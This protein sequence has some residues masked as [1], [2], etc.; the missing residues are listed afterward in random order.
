MAG[1][2]V[3]QAPVT[4][5]PSADVIDEMLEGYPEAEQEIPEPRIDIH[6]PIVPSNILDNAM[7][8]T[9]VNL[10]YPNEVV[11]LPQE[12]MT[13]NGVTRNNFS[14]QHFLTFTDGVLVCSENQAAIVMGQCP[15]VK[16]EPSEGQLMVYTPSGF[17]TRNPAIY[18]EHVERYN[19][20]F[21][22]G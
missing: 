4:D 8:V 21:M 5:G 10:R 9:L 6:N 11:F 16:R 15:Y 12:R 14:P 22:G 20:D 13:E 18:A 19:E 7:S 2:S 17:A 3:Q 1:K